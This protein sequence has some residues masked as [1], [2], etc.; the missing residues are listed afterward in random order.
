MF[1]I[2]DYGTEDDAQNRNKKKPCICIY[3]LYED[4]VKKNC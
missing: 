3:G 2:K 4:K 1:S